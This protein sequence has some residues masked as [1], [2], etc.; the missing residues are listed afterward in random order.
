[1]PLLFELI[2]ITKRIDTKPDAHSSFHPFFDHSKDSIYSK[3][4]FIA[5]VKI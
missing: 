4:V 2:N 5:Q 3:E 1:M